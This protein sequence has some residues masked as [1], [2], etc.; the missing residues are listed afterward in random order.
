MRLPIPTL[1]AAAAIA[2]QLPAQWVTFQDQT[3]T[4]LVAPVAVGS[5]DTQ[6]KDYA[7]A[8]FDQDG[9]VDLFVA[10]KQPF[11]SPGKFPNVLL[12]NEN[13]VLTDRTAQY[14]SA[15]LVPG[16]QGMLDATND[17][18]AVCVDV[19]GDGWIDIVTCTTL[20]ASDPQY[21][22]VPRV[23]INLG[24]DAFGNWQGFLFDDPLRISD[25]PWGGQ[26][27]FCSVA[28]GDIDNDGDMDLYFGDYQQGGT[29]PVDI[30]DR[31]LLNNGSGYFTDVS[32]ARMTYEML[33][34]SFGMKVAMVDMNGD[35]FVDI[36]KDDALNAP[37]AVSISYNIGAANPGFFGAYQLA[38]GNA[39]Y[40]FAVGDL[41]ND[42]LPDMIF[43]D[44][45]QDR[46]KLMTGVSGGIATFGPD[47]A[48][49]Y[50]G[51]G[52]DDGFGGNNLIVDLNNDG[53]QDAIICDVDVDI[54]GCSRRTHIF[55]NLG[56]VPN[57]TM[58]EEQIA[59]AVC[60]IPTSMLVGTFDIAVFDINGD[61]WNDMVIGRCSGTQVWMNIPPTGMSFS[62]PGGLPTMVA[63][64]GIRSFTVQATGIGGV[65]PQ[66][67]SG[68]LHY[69][70]DG[71]PVQTQAMGDL[72]PGLYQATLPAMPACTREVAFHVSVSGGVAGTFTDPPTAPTARH[73]VVSAIGTAVV[74][75]N[76][77]EGPVPGWTVVNT[78]LTG[79]AW[80]VAVP[81]GTTNL[82]QWAAPFEDAEAS[83]TNGR[84]WV[85]QNGLPGGSAGA[86]DVDGG[87]TDLF[88]PPVNLAGT[89][90]FISYRRWFYSAGNDVMEVHVSGDGVNWVLVET[91]GATNNNQWLASSF[92]VGDFIVPTATVRVRWRIQDV[93]P[94]HVVEGAVDV[95]RVEAFTCSMCQENVGLM[96]PGTATFSICGGDLSLGTSA[97]IAVQGTPPFATGVLIASLFN[98]ASPWNGGLLV[99]TIPPIILGIG[100]DGGGNLIVPGGLPGG[101]GDF[102]LYAQVV[103]EDLA[104]PLGWGITNAV[105]IQFKP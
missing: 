2:S 34:S 24:N 48:F 20:T 58:R 54:S 5:G 89:D 85:T 23:Y 70:V 55:Q 15:S 22:R 33:E 17:R 94:A 41:N 37:Q 26:H 31:L 81:V 40:H 66:P 104:Q 18:D 60:G 63:P 10:R 82:G 103:Y 46:Y 27:R 83:T 77:M 47:T 39:P 90:G 30:D 1:A 6:E 28:A 71:G 64:G 97:T 88:S 50:I 102:A 19:N 95:F 44:D 80:E 45:G 62:Y 101:L 32:S 29:R 74:Y 21:I 11:T 42:G 76:N 13:G 68:V 91:I 93:L 52:G 98:F 56:N 14:G 4:R 78:N 67:G 53:F 69:S 75:E 73:R 57:V 96:G 49:T 59:G 65:V 79:G 8:D 105:R 16:S 25:A 87:P 92:R 12:M 43:S 3:S 86:A 36:L 61:G 100:M 35:G 99:D 9:D 51:G 38:Y 84:C 72:G 7:W